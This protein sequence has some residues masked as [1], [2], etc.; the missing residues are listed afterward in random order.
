M[1]FVGHCNL[2]PL[3]CKWQLLPKYVPTALMTKEKG[4]EGGQRGKVERPVRV[5]ERLRDFV[6][7]KLAVR[8]TEA[9]R[10]VPV[11]VGVDVG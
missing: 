11:N 9:F 2:M 5:G 3:R 1:A 7:D 6:D 8:V 4:A 10:G